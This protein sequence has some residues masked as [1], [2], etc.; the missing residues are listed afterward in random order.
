MFF[1]KESRKRERE[2]AGK[3]NCDYRVLV[4]KLQRTN[5]CKNSLNHI[6]KEMEAG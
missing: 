5:S 1:K 6:S 4:A 2:Q 3:P